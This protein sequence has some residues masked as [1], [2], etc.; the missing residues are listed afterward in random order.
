VGVVAAAGLSLAGDWLAARIDPADM[1]TD[2]AEQPPGITRPVGVDIFE[3]FSFSGES[4]PG[5]LSVSGDRA[6]GT[7]LR[8]RPQI[9]AASSSGSIWSFFDCRKFSKPTTSV[10]IILKTAKLPFS[11]SSRGSGTK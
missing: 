7:P 2:G 6:R 11:P 8:Q 1:R 3:S 10:Q 5:G 4:P 9:F